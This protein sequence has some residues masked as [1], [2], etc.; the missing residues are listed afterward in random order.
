MAPSRFALQVPDVQL[1]TDCA[2]FSRH[3]QSR[4]PLASSPGPIETGNEA[5]AWLVDSSLVP[6][7]ETTHDGLGTRLVEWHAC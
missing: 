1:S 5:R 3:L 4:V 2:D 7:D 6:R